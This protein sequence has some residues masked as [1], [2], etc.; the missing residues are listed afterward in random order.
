MMGLSVVLLLGTSIIWGGIKLQKTGRNAQQRVNLRGMLAD[1]FRADVASAA[2]APDSLQQW[3]AGPACLILMMTDGRHVVYQWDG[4]Q[5]LRWD[6]SKGS[7]KIPQRL[8]LDSSCKGIT[9][10]RSVT[11]NQVISLTLTEV[12]GAIDHQ[13]ELVA[14]LGGDRR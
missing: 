13:A 2:A 10:Q 3:Q 11:G 1:Q 8:S 4:K 9:F 12:N 6:N 14:V 7:S 5:L